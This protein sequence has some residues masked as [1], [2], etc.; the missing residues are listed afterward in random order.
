MRAAMSRASAELGALADGA[1]GSLRV[2]AFVSAAQTLVP[3]SL[4][5]LRRE[6]P[7]ISVRLQQSETLRSYDALLRGDLDIAVTF[8]YDQAADPPPKGI[9]RELIRTD[10][11]LI[12]VPAGHP[13]AGENEIDVDGISTAEW[14]ATPVEAQGLPNIRVSDAG[15]PQRLEFDGDDFRTVLN[16]VGA[17]LGVAL[18][19][20]LA[21]ADA[22][23]GIVSRPITRGLNRYIYTCRLQTTHTPLPVRKLSQYLHE[24][25]APA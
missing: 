7:G 9:H 2:G 13:L 11:V 6:H 19:P 18:L 23:P 1:A 20:E 21:L 16:L 22:P 8:D 12:V 5:R 3:A 25:L 15:S 17:G 24:A 10:P 14:I 4:A